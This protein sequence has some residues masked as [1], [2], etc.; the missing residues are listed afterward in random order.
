MTKY[1]SVSLFSGSLGFDLGLEASGRF[2][3]I[4][5]LEAD[6]ACCETIRTNHTAGR[7]GISTTR[8]YEGD[9]R[10]INPLSM[11]RELGLAAGELDLLTAGP[12]CQTFSTTGRRETVQDPRGT[13]LWRTI[14]FIEAFEPKTF[15]LE[16]VRGLL[17]AAL[18]HRPLAK[19]PN[20]GGPPL[21]P[22]EEPGSVIQKFLAD[23]RLRFGADYRVD[24][25]EV[26]AVNYGSSQLRERAI[27]IGNR[28]GRQ[29]EFPKPTHGKGLEPYLTLGHALAGVPKENRPT[30]MDFSPRKKAYLAL[31]PPGGNWRCLPETLQRES[32]GKA[33]FAKGGRSGWWRRLSADLPCPT[34]VTMPN[35]ASTALTHPTELRAL[36]V[37]E[38]AAI[39]GFP[40]SWEFIGTPQEQ[41][42]QVGN[43]VPSVLGEVA[44]KA[45]AECLDKGP[46]RGAK[47]SELV[48]YRRVYLTSHVRTRQ[49]FKSGKTFV[50]QAG[51][52]NKEIRKETSMASQ[53]EF[54]FAHG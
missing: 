29:V 16:N 19:R 12:P 34:I 50:W 42:T 14:D 37:K 11:M 33:F 13:L 53:R 5:A 23:I 32:M 51:G 6:H 36:S 54:E 3:T 44:G 30:I 39:Q 46:E 47:A 21:L 45:L 2:E 43:A 24:V 1:R 15:I 10:L 40:S 9:I 17:S 26:N 27:F 35:H 31:V 18:Q 7:V 20:K 8:V 38:C 41:Y 52:P 22:E 25:F 28:L 49:W 48:P 4:A